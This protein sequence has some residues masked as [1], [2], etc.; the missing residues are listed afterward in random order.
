MKNHQNLDQ[1]QVQA[2][3][4]LLRLQAQYLRAAVREDT[5]E[6]FDLPPRDPDGD[7]IRDLD[8]LEAYVAQQQARLNV[9]AT[10]AASA[11]AHTPTGTPQSATERCLAAKASRPALPVHHY[12]GATAKCLAANATKR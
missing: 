6:D 9:T 5:G 4:D 11:Q 2:K 3:V 12:T 1:D 7:I 8:D 10:P